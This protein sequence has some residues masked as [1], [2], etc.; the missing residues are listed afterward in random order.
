[1]TWAVVTMPDRP[2]GD[3]EIDLLIND[4]LTRYALS[5]ARKAAAESGRE[6]YGIG[7]EIRSASLSARRV[8][9][10]L[11][12]QAAGRLEDG[13]VRGFCL[14]LPDMWARLN[15][16]ALSALGV[17]GTNGLRMSLEHSGAG[18]GFLLQD[19][20][21][22]EL[23][24]IRPGAATL[25]LRY[26]LRAQETAAGLFA[27]REMGAMLPSLYEDGW[28]LART[29]ESLTMY[30]GH[31]ASAAG[32][33]DVAG[34]PAKDQIEFVCARGWI[35]PAQEGL[36]LPDAPITASELLE[37][38][39]RLGEGEGDREIW[40]QAMGIA[41]LCSAAPE[42]RP[43]RAQTAACGLRFLEAMGCSLPQMRT[44]TPPAGEDRLEVISAWRAGLL[45]VRPNGGLEPEAS[46]N[47]ADAAIWLCGL[48]RAYVRGN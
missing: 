28:L 15:G 32:Y 14:N 11:D 38:L 35:A 2:D 12:A 33:A 20:R 25:G 6:A 42:A 40:A 39:Y 41:S 48:S 34:H 21:G 3:G 30:V 31:D 37:A 36:F 8:R 17:Q 10:K 43:T 13:D 44:G 7:L 26:A 24:L 46:C 16:H 27:H 29:A 23:V 5:Q 45:D 4:W 1:M 9:L 47:R 18:L 22:R 19:G